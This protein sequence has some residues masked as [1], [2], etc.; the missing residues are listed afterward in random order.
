MQI[1]IHDN[2]IKNLLNVE[3]FLENDENQED[4]VGWITIMEKADDKNLRSLLKDETIDTEQRETIATG[5]LNGYEYLKTVGISHVDLE[6]ENI[7]F[8]DGTPKIIDFG[9]VE[10]RSR[11]E[12]YREMGFTRRGS[13]YRSASALCKSEK[14]SIKD[15]CF[16]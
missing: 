11:R 3:L 6:M 12:S 15:I 8:L 13:K 9:V 1:P 10:D 16:R 14:S 7:L 4:C 2:V 5:I